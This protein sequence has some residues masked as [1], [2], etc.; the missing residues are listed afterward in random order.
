MAE[1]REEVLIDIRLEKGDNEKQV[2]NLTKKITELQT[3]NKNLSSE[4]KELAKAGKENSE[5]YVE[6]SKQIEINKQ[7]LTEATSSRKGLISTLLAEDNSIK[8]LQV[9]NRELIQQRN[10]INTSTDEGKKKIAEINAEIDKNNE[11]I[12]ENVSNLEKQKINVG[13]YASALDGLIPGF[14]GVVNGIKG[15]TAASLTFIATPIGAILGAIGLA[16]AAV[17]SYLKGTEEGQDKLNVVT[18]VAS[19]IWQKFMDVVR[20]VGEIIVAAVENPQQAIKDLG[21][22]IVDNLINRFNGLLELI[23]NLAKSIQLLFKGEFAEAGRVAF[24]AIAKVT[25]GIEDASG[26]L[27]DFIQSVADTVALAVAEGSKVAALQKE[28]RELERAYSKEAAETSLRVAKIRSDAAQAEGEERRK[29]IAEAIAL[30]EKLGDQAVR[31]AAKKL[32]LARVESDIADNDIEANNKLLAAEVALITAQQQRF[33]NTLRFKRE[34]ETIDKGIAAETEKRTQDELKQIAAREA[35]E[36]KLSELRLQEQ[37]KY[38]ESLEARYQKELELEQ[39]R[40]QNL[41]ENIESELALLE[42]KGEEKNAIEIA[43]EEALQAE[44]Q[45]ILETSQANVNAIYTKFR[46]ERLKQ[47]EAA[48]K[49]QADIDKKVKEGRL[50]AANEISAGVAGLLK[51][52]TE[53]FKIAAVTETGISA[54]SAAQK[55]FE[56]GVQ[57]GG[58]F[59]GLV[60]GAIALAQGLARLATIKGFAEGGLTGTRILPGMGFPIRRSNGDNMLATVRTGEVILN[61]QQQAALGGPEVFRRLGV[62]GFATGGFV[63]EQVRV[64]SQQSNQA[65]DLSQFAQVINQVQTVLVLEE[66]ETKQGDVQ[67]VQRR[68]QVI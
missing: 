40:F 10:L 22:A 2:D 23:P 34:L 11:A 41:T 3:A 26:K 63:G 16:L 56:K 58:L 55:A 31:I 48:A 43:R 59:T 52:G 50:Q 4:N 28:I 9:R 54:Y 61:Q 44:L 49:K 8:G 47:E 20:D 32:E 66:F 12:K 38:A 29:L 36:Q 6:N 7:K 30:E 21:K 1:F 51:E 17:M 64:A 46:D 67:G 27:T 33:D 13:N 60:Q 24:D 35:S 45:L 37:I 57:Q 68:A 15:M 5:Q 14:S 39:L 18:Q 19:A 42:A 65:F 25:V 62:P 53:A